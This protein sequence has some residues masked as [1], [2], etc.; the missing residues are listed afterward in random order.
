MAYKINIGTEKGK[1]YQVETDSPSLEG[2]KIG[3]KIDGSDIKPELKGYQL[4]ITGTSD[5]AGFPGKKDVEGTALTKILT[6]KG[7]A[8][9]KKGV[10]GLRRKRTIRGNTIS[11]KVT[12]INCKVSKKGNKDLNKVFGGE[13][14]KEDQQS[15]E[16]SKKESKESNDQKQQDKESKKQENSKKKDNQDK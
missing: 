12:Q 16:D 11:E 6:K 3:D 14:E 13:Q 1:T 9:K 15:D 7:F 8:M 10:K 2:K 4:E 5:S